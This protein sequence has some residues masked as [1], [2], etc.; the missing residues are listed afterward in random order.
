MKAQ[1]TTRA[2]VAILGA[3]ALSLVCFLAVNSHLGWAQQL[4]ESDSIAKTDADTVHHAVWIHNLRL[5]PFDA[6]LHDEANPNPD[7]HAKA[8]LLLIARSL[9]KALH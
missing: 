1:P 3:V 2:A 5:H 8:R 7:M 9:A 4:P 6:E